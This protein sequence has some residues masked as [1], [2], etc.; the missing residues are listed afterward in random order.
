MK[1]AAKQFMVLAVIAGIMVSTFAMT[2]RAG[3]K[4]S[5]WL[6]GISKAADGNLQMYYKSDT[7]IQLKGKARK[8]GARNKV[9][10]AKE[11]KYSAALK[12][13]DSCKVILQE[14]ENEQV[15][16]YDEWTESREYKKG[17]EITFISATVKVRNH[18]IVRIYFSA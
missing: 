15:M 3:S 10:D 1:K 12:V 13:A 6:T 5:Y 14:A 18:K 2:V 16:P 11:K 7:V 8:A 17:S 9:Y 4:S